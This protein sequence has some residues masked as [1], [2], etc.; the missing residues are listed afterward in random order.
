MSNNQVREFNL[1]NESWILVLE[2]G[3]ATVKVSVL[4]LF[5][6][7]HRY[8]RIAGELPTQD[9][10]IFR[11]LLAV[12]YGVF[13]HVDAHG[14]AVAIRNVEDA[15]R[16]WKSLWDTGSFPMEPMEEYLEYYADRFDLFHP[17]K[18]FYQ[19]AGI[20]TSDGKTNPMTQ[21][22]SDIPSRAERRFFSNR[23][24]D[25][26]GQLD[27]DEAARW[28]IDLHA[29]DYAG[30]KNSVVG[31]SPN[32]GGT[33]WLGKLGVI[34]LT[35]RNLFETLMLN[36]SLVN[37]N[38]LIEVGAPVWER[39]V[40]TVEKRELTPAGYADLL[41]W[42]SRRALLFVEGES[43][44]GV[45]ASYGDVFNKEDRFVEQMSGWHVSS[46]SKEVEK[47]IPNT[48]NKSR[49]LWRDLNALLPLEAD[50]MN[51]K[52]PGVVKWRSYLKRNDMIDADTVNIS[53][54]GMEYGAMMAVVTEMVTDQIAFNAGL[55][56]AFGQEWIP[57]ILSVLEMTERCVSLLG[58]FARDLAKAAGA[59]ARDAKAMESA[60]RRARETAYASLDG[61]FRR[62][63]LSIDPSVADRMDEVSDS[64]NA[65]MRGLI[66][67]IGNSLIDEAGEKSLVGRDADINAPTA[68]LKFKG[69]IYKNIPLK[70]KGGEDGR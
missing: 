37:D 58:M 11:M 4:E 31:G 35:G 15:R 24:G 33:G 5:R 3:G 64:W 10:A 61:P 63:L 7:A 8:K 13:T 59:D 12:L 18:P 6:N 54:V 51:I 40:K 69:S 56:T 32:G 42:Q 70:K 19:V 49:S 27:F 17:E 36:F 34:Y 2:G 43:V 46:E 30:K 9:I 47:Y 41:T 65:T 44:T 38:A 67:D 60:T 52:V 1:L 57:R 23:L 28:L 62:W 14:Q 50:G 68:Y 48:L 29:W 16:Q 55:L 66:L 22:M 25:G 45:V 53:A 21:I 26:I 20:G 39:A